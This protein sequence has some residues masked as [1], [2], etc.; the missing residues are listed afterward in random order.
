MNN[1]LVQNPDRRVLDCY[2]VETLESEKLMIFQY[3]LQLR[4]MFYEQR[5]QEFN[6][7]LLVSAFKCSRGQV[8]Q[9]TLK[10]EQLLLVSEI[11]SLPNY[12]HCAD[13]KQVVLS[14]R[15]EVI[16]AQLLHFPVSLFAFGS[17]GVF[18]HVTLFFQW[19]EMRCC[20]PI[21]RQFLW[22]GFS[23]GFF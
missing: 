4:R 2:K 1:S 18:I 6:V 16:K 9:K 15:A 3:S 14:M 5:V 12:S 10:V 19:V 23:K 20:L 22:N 17:T 11:D 21:S 13:S 7:R 8:L